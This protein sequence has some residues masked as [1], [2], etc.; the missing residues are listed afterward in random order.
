MPSQ[1]QRFLYDVYISHAHE[2]IDWCRM[3]ANRLKEQR[4]KVWF[5]EQKP[6]QTKD[7]SSAIKQALSFS[8][9]IVFVMTPDYFEGKNRFLTESKYAINLDPGGKKGML[10]PI[11]LRDSGVPPLLR[12]F[13][14]IDFRDASQFDRSF[15]ELVEVLREKDDTTFRD[16]QIIKP[17][18]PW[19]RPAKITEQFETA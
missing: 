7:M 1:Q 12:P 2:D 16:S 10:I 17:S 11:L 19:K 14:H 5:D 9:K 18:R 4:F 13:K 15:R 3:L 8:R 6:A